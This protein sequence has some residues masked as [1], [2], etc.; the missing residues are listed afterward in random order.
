MPGKAD[1]Q[2]DAQ[3]NL[4]MQCTGVREQSGVPVVLQ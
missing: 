3:N 1:Q 2:N 4:P